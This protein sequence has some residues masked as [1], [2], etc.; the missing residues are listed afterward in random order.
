[1]LKNQK[2]KV[3]IEN[4]DKNDE[5]SPGIGKEIEVSFDQIE[6]MFKESVIESEEVRIKYIKLHYLYRF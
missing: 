6:E 2:L 5:Q 1:M 4:N 3:F